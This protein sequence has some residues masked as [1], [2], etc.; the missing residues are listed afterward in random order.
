M[1][2]LFLGTASS[3]VIQLSSTRTRPR[4]SRDSAAKVAGAENMTSV[5]SAAKSCQ[6]GPQPKG[7]I[8]ILA[9]LVLDGPEVDAVGSEVPL[10]VRRAGARA[11]HHRVEARLERARRRAGHPYLACAGS[12]PGSWVG[13]RAISR[14]LLQRIANTGARENARR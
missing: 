10:G 7:I 3:L 4:L 14:K 2:R 13:V 9:D 12:G 11:Q 8:C 1:P 6:I 5:T